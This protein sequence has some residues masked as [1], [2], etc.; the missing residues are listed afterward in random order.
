MAA[1]FLSPKKARVFDN[2]YCLDREARKNPLISPVYADQEAL[3]TFPPT[4]LLTA[5]KDSLCQ[6]AEKFR[7]LLV[8][9]G[10]TVSHKRFEDSPHGF[11][12]SEKS[13]AREGWTMM[14]EHLKKYI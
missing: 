10:V 9:A 1:I 5:G 11:T 13:D 12:L 3:K 8:S 14:I 7:D 2:C 4:V 6:E